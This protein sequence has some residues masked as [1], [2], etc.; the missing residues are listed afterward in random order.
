MGQTQCNDPG[1]HRSS[2]TMRLS[3]QEV[4]GAIVG[5]IF[6]SRHACL[7]LLGRSADRCQMCLWPPFCSLQ[8]TAGHSLPT[9]LMSPVHLLHVTT[10]L[11]LLLHSCAPCNTSCTMVCQAP[12]AIKHGDCG[13]L[14]A[15][16]LCLT[17]I[18]ETDTSPLFVIWAWGH[19]ENYCAH[20]HKCTCRIRTEM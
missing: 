11:L 4:P 13:L 2:C 20:V 5:V 3:Y 14:L 15:S 1:L 19:A 16:L 7:F 9:T 6:G 8:V 10:L 12:V 18:L 17:Y